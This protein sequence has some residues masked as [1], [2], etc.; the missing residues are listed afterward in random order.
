GSM[1]TV[2]MIADNPGTWM[3]HCHVG[4]HMEDGMMAVF[5]IYAP[6][7]RQCPVEFLSGDLW[8]SPQSMSLTVKNAGRKPISR[9]FITS[10][11]LLAPQD[12]R[13]PANSQWSAKNAI[14]AGAEQ[15]VEK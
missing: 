12:L 1:K 15:V 3:F 7:R 8:N 14:T 10:E 9:L 5:T 6:T 13:R 2:D 4:E 11:I